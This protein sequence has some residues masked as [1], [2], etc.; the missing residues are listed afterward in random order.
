[1]IWFWTSWRWP[2]ETALDMLLPLKLYI[3]MAVVL[4]E[5]LTALKNKRTVI[6]V[7]EP[8]LLMGC[9]IVASKVKTSFFE[10]VFVSC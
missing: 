7:I 2:V 1:M 10:S 5:L 8:T 3:A 4:T 9:V 6:E